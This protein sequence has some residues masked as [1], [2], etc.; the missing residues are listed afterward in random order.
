MLT[1][2]RSGEVRNAD[3]C[4]IDLDNRVWTIPL[5]KMKA[6][7]AHRVPLSDRA[8]EI[9]CEAITLGPGD[10]LVFPSARGTTISD[11][12]VSKLIREQGTAA[13][14]H[15]FRS[16]FRDWCGET[17]QPREIAE[18]A[19]AHAVGNQIEA[20]YARSDLFERRRELMDAWAGYLA[21]K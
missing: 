5:E 20:A 18:A 12:T 16:S 21:R 1:A 17:G 13:V 10:G 15:G 9:L 4:E 6:G 3:W 19:L 8:V 14:P 2:A 11:M 7:K